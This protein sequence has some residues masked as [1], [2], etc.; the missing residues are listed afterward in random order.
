MC[1]RRNRQ[2]FRSDG[3]EENAQRLR[4]VFQTLFLDRTIDPDSL[5]HDDVLCFDHH[6]VDTCFRF[7]EES[8]SNSFQ[9]F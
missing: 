4:S 6:A 1:A 3:R 8:S 9:T 7:L 2:H 5:L